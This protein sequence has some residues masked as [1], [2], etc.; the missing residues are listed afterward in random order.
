[1]LA[2]LYAVLALLY[3]VL[4]LLYAVLALLY[5]VLALLYAVLALLYAVIV[6]GAPS[7]TVSARSVTTSFGIRRHPFERA[8]PT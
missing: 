4:A 8:S 2:L 6:T 5:A 7:G 1:M 3:A